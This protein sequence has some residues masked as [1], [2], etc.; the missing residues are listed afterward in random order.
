MPKT[1]ITKNRTWLESQT[2]YRLLLIAYVG[3][4]AIAVI[5]VLFVASMN[6][7]QISHINL[8]PNGLSWLFSTAVI[9]IF[10]VFLVFELLKRI[11]LYAVIQE[12]FSSGW[13]KSLFF[14]VILFLAGGLALNFDFQ[15]QNQNLLDQFNSEQAVEQQQCAEQQAQQQQAEKEKDAAAA[16]TCLSKADAAN[17]KALQQACATLS[18]DVE[19][20][21]NTCQAGPE[22]CRN[23]YPAIPGNCDLTQ[24]ANDAGNLGESLPAQEMLS[25]IDATYQ[26]D[27]NSC[28]ALS[29][30]TPLTAA[31]IEAAQNAT[32]T[33]TAA[34]QICTDIRLAQLYPNS[35]PVAP[36]TDWLSILG[37]A[38][39]NFENSIEAALAKL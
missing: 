1:N 18:K 13:K 35:K 4:Y 21:Y 26:Q 5:T 8:S 24:I 25:T 17:Q 10:C 19:R 28:N 37:E 9:G 15:Q 33:P 16:S 38:V 30:G 22:Y 2:W 39:N 7:P 23:L 27:K 36:Q 31:Q 14:F 34:Q 11:F 12:N 32:T 29:Y 3:A 20:D 6:L